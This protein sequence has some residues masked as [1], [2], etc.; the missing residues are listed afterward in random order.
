[1]DIL[2]VVHLSSLKFPLALLKL[3]K[4]AEPDL[5]PYV[6]IAAATAAWWLIRKSNLLN[7]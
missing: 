2:A 7:F 4:Q 6:G 1:M 3:L 5:V